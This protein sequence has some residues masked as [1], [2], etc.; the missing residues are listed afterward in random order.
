MACS[1]TTTVASPLN[2]TSTSYLPPES[3]RNTFAAKVAHVQLGHAAYGH[4]G[5]SSDE[6]SC[7]TSGQVTVTVTVT[8][9]GCGAAPEAL[10][11]ARSSAPHVT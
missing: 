5:E 11:S 10:R 9:G 8:G 7:N 2:S 6:H 1:L 4:V 3:N